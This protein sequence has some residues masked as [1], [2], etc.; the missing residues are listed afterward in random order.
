MTTPSSQKRPR[1]RFSKSQ[2]KYFHLMQRAV[3][4][5]TLLP[6]PATIDTSDPAAMAD[7]M[8]DVEMILNE[9]N[10]INREM[11]EILNVKSCS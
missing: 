7:V 4:I 11:M 5:A 9:F 6:D 8:A 1:G 2:A 10:K 3:Q